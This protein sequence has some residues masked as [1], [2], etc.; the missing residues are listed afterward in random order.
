[1]TEIER[2]TQATV[3]SAVSVYLTSAE[4][5]RKQRKQ[6]KQLKQ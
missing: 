3:L 6:G 1:M 4:R 2:L 5:K